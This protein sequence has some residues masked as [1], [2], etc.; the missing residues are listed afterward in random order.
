VVAR[1]GTAL[2]VRVLLLPRPFELEVGR[3]VKT[4]AN[5][6]KHF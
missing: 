6:S 1:A 2:A 3:V 5:I 4:N